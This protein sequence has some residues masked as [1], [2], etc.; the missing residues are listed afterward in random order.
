MTPAQ[1][2]P[3]QAFPFLSLA[4][5]DRLRAYG[6]EQ[7]FQPG[8]VILR[9]GHRS[10]AIYVLLEGRVV[11]QKEHSGRAVVLDEL[12]PGAVFGEVSYLDSSPT[13]AAVVA[14][15]EVDV[16]VLEDLDAILASDPSLGCG[17]YRSIA[18]LLAR[19][20]RFTTAESA[21]VSQASM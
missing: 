20:L 14:R 12:R 11:V 8:G 3:D 10:H 16:F 6:R 9:E 18:S 19:R 17:F 13:T 15:G 1:H 2:L 21:R 7:H 4:E 5:R